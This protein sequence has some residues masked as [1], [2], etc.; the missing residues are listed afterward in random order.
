MF[1]NRVKP[2][3]VKRGGGQYWPQD[4]LQPLQQKLEEPVTWIFLTFPQYVIYFVLKEK[5]IVLWTLTG[6]LRGVSNR[7]SSYFFLHILDIFTFFLCIITI[8]HVRS[9][10]IL[11]FGHRYNFW[12][13]KIILVHFDQHVIF[14]QY[15]DHIWPAILYRAWSCAGQHAH[16]SKCLN[17]VYKAYRINLILYKKFLV[18]PNWVKIR[19]ILG[20]QNCPPP[21]PDV[22]LKAWTW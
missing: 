3:Q 22:N 18:K 16:D 14:T 10:N 6:M 13:R 2:Y 9:I 21:G 8:F 20:G 12:D 7:P 5:N 19:Q 4:F 11:T 17:D 1:L 15:F